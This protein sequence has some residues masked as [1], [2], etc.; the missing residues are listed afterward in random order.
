MSLHRSKA[1]LTIH[2]GERSRHIVPGDLVDFAERLGPK[3]TMGDCVSPEYFE[4]ADPPAPAKGQKKAAEE[5]A[6]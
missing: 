6:S 2:A 5:P 3:L 4:P 1:F